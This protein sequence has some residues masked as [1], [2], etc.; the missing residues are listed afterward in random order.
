MPPRPPGTTA[1][2]VRSPPPLRRRAGRPRARWA[3]SRPWCAPGFAPP[4]GRLVPPARP[5]SPPELRG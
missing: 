3:P 1:A 5:G 4:P 2:G